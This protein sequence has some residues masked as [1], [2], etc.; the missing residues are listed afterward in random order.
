VRRRPYRPPSPD[1]PS[2]LARL[3]A[4]YDSLTDWQRVRYGLAGMLFFV[5]CA[6][7]LLGLGSTTLLRRVEAD[8]GALILGERATPST[9]AP[10]PP[11]E[12]YSTAVS[13]NTTVPTSTPKPATPLPT[14]FSAPQI[15]EMPVVRRNAPGAPA[16]NR[17]GAPTGTAATPPRLRNTGATATPTPVYTPTV[18][19][20]T[21][22]PAQPEPDLTSEPTMPVPTPTPTAAAAPEPPPA[23]APAASPSPTGAPT[24]SPTATQPAAK[25]STPTPRPGR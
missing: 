19:P 24:A 23:T 8:E 16:T 6:G 18:E 20:E 22:P 4:W 13:E 5:A 14:P 11:V 9:E 7:Y 12:G 10:A 3:V 1:D 15:P 2:R 17:L 25:T 21:N